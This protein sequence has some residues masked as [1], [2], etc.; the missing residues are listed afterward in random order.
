MRYSRL[1]S[2]MKRCGVAEAVSEFELVPFLL[3]I[4][5]CSKHLRV[6]KNIVIHLPVRRVYPNTCLLLHS[7]PSHSPQALLF[8]NQAPFLL[9]STHL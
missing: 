4:I 5:Y 6:V 2:F 1:L 7:L 8:I 9:G 3:R